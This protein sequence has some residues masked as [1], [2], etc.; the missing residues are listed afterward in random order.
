MI[1][2]IVLFSAKNADDVPEIRA[3]LQKLGEIPGVRHLEVGVNAKRDMIDNSI[4]LVLYSEFDDFET[5]DAYKAHPEY[6]EA[7]K[8][9]RHLRETRIAVDFEA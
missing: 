6:K 9:V 5:L 3:G 1:R 4:D 8:A 7:I 2:H